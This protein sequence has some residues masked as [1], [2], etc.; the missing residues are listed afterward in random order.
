MLNQDDD[1][2]NDDDLNE[3]NRISRQKNTCF[4]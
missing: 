4:F 1:F 3:P 2:D